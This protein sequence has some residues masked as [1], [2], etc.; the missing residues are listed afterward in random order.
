MNTIV[1][2]REDI[3]KNS[4]EVL[5]QQGFD[6]FSIRAVA[7]QSGVA[8]GSIYHYFQSK[9]ELLC[10]VT[11]SIWYEIFHHYES[12]RE[13]NDTIQCIDWIWECLQYGQKQYPDFITYHH[14]LFENNAK[15]TAKQM[16]KEKKDHI[17]AHFSRIME[18]DPHLRRN[19]F[20]ADFTPD[21][22][23]ELLL[24]L[25]IS[26]VRNQTSSIEPIHK[27][28]KRTIY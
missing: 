11:E 20:D 22:F 21:L 23:A 7:M 8:V 24:T 9:T 1:T 26:A 6:K 17:A 12:P 3:L 16:M 5:R 19:A 25:L 13:M 2:S 28:V 18:Q 15:D 10:A 14:L 27:L 4:R